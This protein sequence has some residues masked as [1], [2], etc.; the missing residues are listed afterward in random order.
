MEDFMSKG[1]T[2]DFSFNEIESSFNSNAS[3]TGG[4]YK[5]MD[6]KLWDFYD[7]YVENQAK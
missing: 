6:D 5:N 1:V 7:R 3:S 2:I 4:G